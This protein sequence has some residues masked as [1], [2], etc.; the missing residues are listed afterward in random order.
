MA[1]S[2]T[3]MMDFPIRQKQP[4]AQTHMTADLEWVLKFHKT[5]ALSSLGGRQFLEAAI[6]WKRGTAIKDG[7]PWVSP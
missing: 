5:R 2:I 1:L 7:R 4:S 6:N 3:I